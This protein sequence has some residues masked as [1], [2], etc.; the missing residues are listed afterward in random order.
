MHRQVLDFWFDE[1]EPAL[2]FKK[3]DDFDRLLHTRFGQIWQAAAAGELAHWRETIEGRLAEVIVLDQFSRNLFRGTPRS[4]ASD[5]MALVLAQEAIRSGQ[6]E[7]LSKE[8]RGFLYLPFMHSESALIHQQAL[9]LYTEL[10][11][12]DQ[13]E[14]ELRHKAIIDRFGRY[15]HRNAI[16][17]RVSTSEEEAFLLLPGSGF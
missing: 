7:Q 6:C 2:W 3:D 9:A 5:C 11:S 4:F 8:Q 14:F 16:L 12:G 15:P 10:D 13:L 1:I 17:G